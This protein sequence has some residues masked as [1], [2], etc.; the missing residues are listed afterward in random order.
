MIRVTFLAVFLLLVSFGS[1]SAFEPPPI[2]EGEKF[3]TLT[4]N[5]FCPNYPMGCGEPP[6]VGDFPGV[7]FA[8]GEYFGLPG[9]FKHLSIGAAEDRVFDPMGQKMETG[10]VWRA[11]LSVRW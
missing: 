1:A 6:R 11:F 5:R 2:L 4:V 3:G 8:V 10:A 9:P 7:R